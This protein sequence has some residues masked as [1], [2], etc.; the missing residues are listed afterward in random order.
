MIG[1]ARN[2]RRSGSQAETFCS[3]GGDVAD[4][5]AG[6][7]KFSQPLRP[8]SADVQQFVIPVLAMKIEKAALQRPVSFA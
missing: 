2:D 5:I 3:F 6:P 7:M 8:Y 4:D 1:T